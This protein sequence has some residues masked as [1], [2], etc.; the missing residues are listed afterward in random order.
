MV[1]CVT[2]LSTRVERLP[3][4]IGA[5]DGVDLRLNGQG[6]AERHC[7]VNKVKTHGLC[8]VK[9]EANLPLV[10]DGESVEFCKLTPDIDYAI[11][12]GAHFL[13]LRGSRDLSSWL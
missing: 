1:D 8:I 13:A 12:V 4:E 11:K 6:V 9:Q 5:G 10:V 2:G 7:A 3:F